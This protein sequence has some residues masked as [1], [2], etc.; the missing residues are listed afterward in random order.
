MNKFFIICFVVVLILCISSA[1][2]ASKC[3][4]N[5]KKC[6]KKD[7]PMKFIYQIVTHFK[8]VHSCNRVFLTKKWVSEDNVRMI[9]YTAEL[10]ENESAREYFVHF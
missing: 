7:T 2:N 6:C 9:S 8:E 3:N 4:C 1:D 5:C 10:N